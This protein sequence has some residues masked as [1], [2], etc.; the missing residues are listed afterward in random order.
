MKDELFDRM[1]ERGDRKL[2]TTLGI[3]YEELIQTSWEFEEVTNNDDCVMEVLVKF[4]D[5]SPQ[6]ILN[7]ISG[8][9]RESNTVSLMPGE[10]GGDESDEDYGDGVMDD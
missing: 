3:T 6:E 7:K 8:L 4:G 9:D 5:D 10:L 1:E 2:A